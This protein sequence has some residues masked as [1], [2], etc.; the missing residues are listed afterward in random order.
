MNI[1]YFDLNRIVTFELPVKKI[2]NFWLK[3]EKNKNVVNIVAEDGRWLLSPSKISTI[4]DEKGST[5]NLVLSPKKFYGVAVEDK[6]YLMMADYCSDNSYSYYS[7]PDNKRISIGKSD[8]NNIVLPL[9][10]VSGEH[11]ILETKEKVWNLTV[12]NNSVVYLNDKK[13]TEGSVVC[14]YG[15][16]INIYGTKFIL[17]NGYLI[18]NNPFGNNLVGGMDKADISV[19]DELSSEEIEDEDLYE[20]EDY[21]L[22]SPRLRKEIV[23]YD[24]IIDSPPAKENTQEAPFWATIVPM[25]TMA[26]SSVIT[27]SNAITEITSGNRTFKQMLPTLVISVGMIFTM[28]IWPIIT[29]KM[30]AKNKR[31]KEAR[32]Q[33]LYQQ[34]INDKA[35]KLEVEY[36][37][38]KRILEE[39]IIS[40][41]ACYDMILNKR[42]TLWSRRKDQNDFL[43][44]RVGRGNVGFDVN[45]SYQREDFTMDDD[46][47]KQMLDKL[48]NCNK[49]IENVPV[50]YSFTDNYLTA[51]NGI[52]PKYIKFVNNLL[53]QFMAFHSYDDLK[54][55]VFTNNSNEDRW[56]Y[57]RESPYCFS[58]N[59]NIRFFATNSEE[60]EEVSNYLGQVLE[61]RRVL[62]NDVKFADYN[63]AYY[64]VIVDDIDV[65]RKVGIIESLTKLKTNLGFSLI[66]LEEK[67]SKIASEITQLIIIGE[68]TS[69]ILNMSNNNQIKFTEEVNDTYDM[70]K[71]TSVLSNLPI[72][73]EEAAKGLPNMVSFLELFGVGKIEQLNVLNRWKSN[74]PTRS[75]RTQVGINT[76][77]DPFMLDLHEKSHGPHGLIA[78]MTGSGKSEFLIT[79]VLSMAINYSPEE[80]AFVLIDYKGGGLAGSFVDNETGKKIPHIIG[81]ITNLDKTEINR[82][83]ASINSELE[84][85][86]ALFNK[87]REETGEGTVDIYKY[88]KL[89]REGVL[90]EPIPHLIIVSDEFAE[91][92]SQQPQFMDDLISTARIGRSLGVHLILATQ[93]P[94]GVVDSQIWS[95]AKFKVCL[96]VQDKQDSMEMIKND[97]AAEIKQVGRFY[98]LVGYN[99]YFSMGQAAWAG[100]QYYPNDEYKKAVDKNLYVIDNVGEVSQTINNGIAKMN[101]VPAGEE[102]TNVVKYLIDIGEENQTKTS[103]LWLDRIPEKVYINDLATKYNYQTKPFSINPIL[104]EYDD[105]AV[106]EQGLLTIDFD[107]NGNTII[108]GTNES[109]KDELL[110]TIVYD[111]LSRYTSE[112]LNLYL[113]DFGAETLSSYEEAPQ[114]GDVILNGD[115]EKIKNLSKML[116]SELN[117]RKKLFKQYGG[118][119]EGYIKNSGKKIPNIVVVFNSIE[120]LNEIYTEITDTF[121]STI[122][123]GNKYGMYFVIVTETQS[124]VKM[125]IS[126]SC[127]N[128]ICLQMN[129][130]NGYRDILGNTNGLAPSEVLGR[131]FIKLDRICE[132]Q[133]ASISKDKDDYTCAT[134]LVNALK[135]KNMPKAKAVPVMPDNI[136][137]AKMMLLYHGLDSVPLGI[138]KDSLNIYTYDFKKNVTTMVSSLEF[139][140]MGL[141]I[142][143]FV[144]ILSVSDKFQTSII[145][146]YNFYELA[147]QEKVNYVNSNYNEFVDKI[148]VVD[149]T[150]QDM[151]SKN[152]MNYK[153]IENIKN[154]VFVVIGFEK[155]MNKLDDD[156]KKVFQDILNNNKEYPKMNF[157]VF[158]IP[159]GFKKYEYEEW[160]KNNFDG[161]SGIWVGGNLAQ[162][163]TIKTNTQPAS[164]ALLGNDYIVGVKN[165]FPTAVKTVNEIKQ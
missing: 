102:L 36:E 123:D 25:L 93:K 165:G 29:R 35:R 39:N 18:M 100:A 60:M 120:T 136:E 125:K 41:D 95:N 37:N 52:Y 162:Q 19:S 121:V 86:Q 113:V 14:H 109:G 20:D 65:A 115:D 57:L 147:P 61:S 94:S 24:L 159:F 3:D 97:L 66:V 111:M 72:R 92:K 90:K 137:I 131:G 132:F 71:C 13:V 23:T 9:A 117:D 51:I 12:L 62:N 156:H 89:Y 74:N 15:D 49:I 106:Q 70:E 77:G 148:K 154:N 1:Y 40:T 151:L 81:T 139:T 45:I 146:A 44:A 22:K 64:L 142:K 48:I 126:Q 8:S 73:I 144:K 54:I 116:I 122:R 104:G 103:P 10:C 133:T 138:T 127:K 6:N 78:G 163:F 157:I 96:K 110:Q 63:D 17:I 130:I 82:A 85:R 140:N 21:F 98:L 53:L 27:V 76:I 114:V 79:Y 56:K 129:N 118:N 145:D 149:D 150:I 155:F 5:E 69:T 141:F 153:S 26:A 4:T 91:L 101:L 59:K 28:I 99:E 107:K 84:R 135:T 164:M 7:V 33:D 2:G 67:L 30:D 80:V 134:E 42:R 119:Y 108:Y 34:Y 88:Q 112:E 128:A 32:R 161:N 47:L 55:V 50:A 124:S 58:N 68:N 160:Y 11:A 158:D 87:V 152:N 83:L 143:N 46:N 75:L 43:T 105:P 38:Q 16:I 31:E